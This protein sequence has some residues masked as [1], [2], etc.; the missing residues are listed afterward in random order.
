MNPNP[1]NQLRTLSAQIIDLFSIDSTYQ[2]AG[3]LTLQLSYRYNR[4]KSRKL[5]NERLKLA[6][7]DYSLADNGLGLS[8]KIDPKPK[9]RIPRLNLILFFC[10][11]LSVYVV[12]VFIFAGGAAASWSE[13]WTLTMQALADGRGIVF[14]IALMSIL[15]VHEMAHFIAG[16]RR[17]I[18]TSWPYFIPAPNIIG[19]FGAV[20]KSKTPFWNRR[21]LI[22]VGASGP[23]AGW[24]IAII[25][26]VWG[27][28]D[29]YVLYPAMPIPEGLTFFLEGESLLIHWL[30]PLMIGQLPLNSA[31]VLS[32]AA[33]AGWVG[34][35]ITA[36]NML[37][38]GQLDGGHVMYGLLHRHQNRLGWITMAGLV[39]L[40]YY[41]PVW[42]FFAGMGLL[43]RVKHPP[44]LEDHRP[45]SRVAIWMGI[46]ALAIFV[47]SFTPIPF[48]S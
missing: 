27:M 47:I 18:I 35:F 19:S 46:L 20:I 37:P 17:G 23:I 15:L 28:G 9:L 10:T 3:Q 8:L 29:S 40:G 6:G 14:T 31:Y 45:V 42:W 12:P 26:L 5:L 34:L 36:I 22:E 32:E 30:V 16:R 25:W 7:Y 44:T 38:I 21:D 48:R 13:A 41:S 43:F 4:S 1:D 39:G 33:F 24:I 11:I 2:Q